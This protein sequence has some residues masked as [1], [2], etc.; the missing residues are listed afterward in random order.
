MK[1][2]LPVSANQD[3]ERYL[4]QK[5]QSVF[6]MA[7]DLHLKGDRAR[8]E[9]AYYEAVAYDPQHPFA[10]NNLGT[11]LMERGC[12]E[13]AIGFYRRALAVKPI[14]P[15]A[16]NNL[17]NALKAENRLAEAIEAYGEGL[18]Q[19]PDF[20]DLRYND[21]LAHLKLGNMPECWQKFES[22]W[23]TVYLKN[24]QRNFAQPRYWGSVPLTGKS[25][26]LH[27]E[28]GMGDTLQMVRYVRLLRERGAASVY[29]E[30]QPVLKGLLSFMP[31]VTG[32]YATGEPL[33]PFDMYC[34]MMSLP[35]VFGT[36][37]ETIP[38]EVPYLHA[39][40]ERVARLAKELENCPHPRIGVC[41]KGNPAFKHDN[42]RSPG[43]NPFRNLLTTEGVRFVSLV[44]DSRAEFLKA[45]GSSAFDLGRELLPTAEGFEETAALIANLDLVITSDTSVCHLAGA[46]GKPV[47]ILLA[48]VAADWRWLLDREDS[49]WYPTARL[50]RQKIR[51]DWDEVIA[52]VSTELKRFEN[53]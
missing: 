43:L 34:P 28:Q 26:L 45:A 3:T 31:E 44:P 2:K 6:S 21:A 33:P 51:G 47:W 17:G 15:E 14:F 7:L 40:P 23:D 10:L 24:A 49:P 52:R 20:K 13:N 1:P 5:A 32:V 19:K 22:R 39:R 30:V 41:W 35:L 38:K 16:L 29:L 36:T 37:L 9:A 48:L 46:M 12:N 11:L 53:K 50:F 18:R 8:A 27:V 4:N 25:I 42:E